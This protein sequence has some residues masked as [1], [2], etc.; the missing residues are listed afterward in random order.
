M[1]EQLFYTIENVESA[2][3]SHT[4]TVNLNAEHTIYKAHFPGNPITP[5][6]CLIQMCLEIL[7]D[8][9]SR[10]LRMVEAK[11]IKYLKVINPCEYPRVSF[12]MKLKTDDHGVSADVSIVDADTVFTKINA[13]Y[14]FV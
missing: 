9:Y 11:N 10:E 5:G 12:A 1:L 6:V 3:D 14:T 4:V 2:G 13:R 7:K 8:K